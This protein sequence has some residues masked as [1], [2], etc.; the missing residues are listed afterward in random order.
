[1]QALNMEHK[2]SPGVPKFVVE[3]PEVTIDETATAAGAPQAVSAQEAPEGSAP[4][5]PR[6]SAFA[7]SATS[8]SINGGE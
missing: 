4:K 3:K 2:D 5:R 7:A 1:M 6:P 8:R